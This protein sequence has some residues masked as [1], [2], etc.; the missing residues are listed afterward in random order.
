MY[1]ES[2]NDRPLTQ[3][4][5]LAELRKAFESHAR[6][7]EKLYYAD[8]ETDKM[9]EKSLRHNI[10]KLTSDRARESAQTYLRE[11]E[12]KKEHRKHV[13]PNISEHIINAGNTFLS[14]MSIRN[15][16]NGKSVMDIISSIHVW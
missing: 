14:K 13:P 8:Q 5:D 10:G 7:F 1:T 15:G 6:A 4:E 2:V 16:I 11:I 3:E 9:V 12:M